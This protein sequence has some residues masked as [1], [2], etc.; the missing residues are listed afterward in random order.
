[1]VFAETCARCH[2]SK[3]PAPAAG[4]DPA[5]CNGADYL[6]C[7]NRY[8]AWT[9]TDE[10]KTADARHRA[11][12]GFPRRQL[13]VQRR[14]HSGNAAA[15]QRLQPARHQRARA[16]ISGI[17]SRRSRYKDLP[18]VGDITVHDPFTG[19]PHQWH[20]P[21]GGRG[22]TRVAVADQRLVHRAVPAEQFASA[23]SSR[24]RRCDA[25][26]RVFQRLDRAN[27]VAGEATRRIRCWATPYRALS[28]ARRSEA[29]SPFPSGYVPAIVRPAEALAGEA[30]PQFINK[31]GDI[32]IGPIPAGI[33][34]NLLANIQLLAESDNFL[35]QLQ[36]VKQLV[37]LLGALAHD[38]SAAPPNATD[39][40]LRA[41]FVNL[42]QPML[43]LSKCPDFVVN[44]GHY[45][46]TDKVPG[47]QG[48]RRMPTSRL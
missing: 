12:A 9:K 22:Y 44:R 18:S 32:N 7:W 4:A 35:D 10:F 30:L 19:E 36:H 1:M 15:D 38:L 17:T 24:I 34:I 42:A 43:A 33:P 26:M 23:H 40:E 3:A 31:D 41:K 28:I 46:G 8:W 48:L 2:S 47:E 11:C 29:G 14:A 16:A 5:G 25:R 45:F 20:M 37:A 39:D 21:A 13:P 27:A 6:T